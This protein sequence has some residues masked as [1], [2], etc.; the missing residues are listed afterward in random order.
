MTISDQD[1]RTHFPTVRYSKISKSAQNPYSKTPPNGLHSIPH[2][3]STFLLR[4]IQ[5]FQH[6]KS[7]KEAQLVEAHYVFIRFNG[8]K[9]EKLRQ[10]QK[11]VLSTEH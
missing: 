11:L 9:L 4:E 1:L 3:R 8:K 5:F 2:F 7:Q 6:K 10:Q